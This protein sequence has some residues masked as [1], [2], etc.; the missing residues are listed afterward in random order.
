MPSVNVVNG[1]QIVVENARPGATRA[2]ASSLKPFVQMWH[3][4]DLIRRSCAAR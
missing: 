2:C 4:Q 3:H 1:K